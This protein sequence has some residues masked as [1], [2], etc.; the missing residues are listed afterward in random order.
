M[1]GCGKWRT[2]S[3]PASAISV[4]ISIPPADGEFHAPTNI[5]VVAYVVLNNGQ[6]G[7]VVN[8]DFFA[9]SNKFGSAKAK[10]H[11]AVFPPNDP[12][13]FHYMHVLPAGFDPLQAVWKKPRPG[14]YSL[15]AKASGP[16]G[17]SA[18]SQ[19][20]KITVLPQH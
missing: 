11:G 8:V 14:S 10:W 15:T 18:V 6:A 3:S 4:E 2:G 7:D 12:H 17:L 13:S 16:N 1:G 9:N 5:E 20:V 19:P